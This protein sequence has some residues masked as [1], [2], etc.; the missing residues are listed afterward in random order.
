MESWHGLIAIAV[1]GF[2]AVSTMIMLQILHEKRHIKGGILPQG[3]HNAH[4]DIERF[5]HSGHKRL[6]IK[7]YR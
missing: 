1:V 2:T 3:L 7:R 5:V 6:A 4:E